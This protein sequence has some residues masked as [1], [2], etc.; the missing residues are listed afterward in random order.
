MKMTKYS[1][2]NE[3]ERIKKD[4]RR[5]ELAEQKERRDKKWLSRAKGCK[6][7]RIRGLE[8][9]KYSDIISSFIYIRKN[10]QITILNIMFLMHLSKR[11]S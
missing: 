1:D 8:S 11:R 10:H 2:K 3:K 5:K 9:K 4:L 6:N 7:G